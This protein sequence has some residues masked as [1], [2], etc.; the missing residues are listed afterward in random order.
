MIINTL[1]RKFILL[2]V[3]SLS[4][5]FG[6]T[7]TDRV[8][9]EGKSYYVYPHQ[10]AVVSIQEYYLNFA[11]RKE[12]IKRDERNEK[13]V[14]VSEEPITELEKKAAIKF[15]KSYKKYLKDFE[16]V[17]EK[18][19]Y[20]MVTTDHDV[21]VDP[22]PA[23]VNLPDGE[24]VMFYRDIPYISKRVLRYKNDIV[25]AYFSI[26]NNLIE[27]KSTWFTP[28]GKIVKTGDY[29]NSEKTGT[30]RLFEY[31]QK[32]DESYTYDP[33]ESIESRLE[34]TVYDTVKTTFTF[35]DG[36]KN[37]PFSIYQNQELLTSGN[38]LADQ[39][40]G[41]WEIYKYKTVVSVDKKGKLVITKGKEKILTDRYTY[42]SD[43]KRG[44][45]PIIR[46]GVIPYEFMGY[47][48]SDSLVL[49]NNSTPNTSEYDQGY[50]MDFPD[51]GTF[52][53]ILKKEPDNIELPEENLTSY[54]GEE[55]LYEGEYYDYVPE[56]EFPTG[57]D[58]NPNE[59]YEFVN[60]KRYKL[61]DLIDSM[62]YLYAYEGIVEHY[63]ENGQLQYRFE[64]KD[65]KLLKEEPV[66]WDNGTI[67]NEV[68]FIA[69]S[70]QYVQRFY[71]YNGV[72]Y[73]E[74][75]HDSKGNILSSSYKRTPDFLTIKGKDY[76]RNYGNP[77]WIYSE[78]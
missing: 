51:F 70:N 31:V 64:V 16:Q 45:S 37:G 11:D 13:I 57:E 30:W 15:P 8:T 38:F 58:Y 40:S 43:E 5:L 55:E 49:T 19:P 21:S 66:Y 68:I 33:K 3:L 22:T 48:R 72:K 59:F 44:K 1:E 9:I 63:Y 69:D 23:L 65:G 76:D 25:A 27:G 60:K 20:F 34:K 32:I 14:S 29:L 73:Y 53:S 46:H 52:L 36:L 50:S 42:R 4:S 17:L 56:L 61:N 12:V 10:Q 39:N 71:D 28:E 35:L 26:R 18:Y 7:Q 6:Y 41:T 67:A 77:T 24:Y 75:W 47:D 74:T 2:I 62:G 78:D 54:E